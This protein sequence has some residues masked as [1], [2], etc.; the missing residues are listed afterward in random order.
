MREEDVNSSKAASI[1]DLRM[2]TK[3]NGKEDNFVV[4]MQ[5]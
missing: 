1:K 4:L 2:D 3:I 5:Y